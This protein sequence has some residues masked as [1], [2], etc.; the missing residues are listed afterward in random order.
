[1][2]DRKLNR[3][4][5]EAFVPRS[6]EMEEAQLTP[7]MARLGFHPVDVEQ[8]RSLCYKND[9][10]PGKVLFDR[11]PEGFR[12]RFLVPTITARQFPDD[13]PMDGRFPFIQGNF[14]DISNFLND[15]YDVLRSA[16]ADSAKRMATFNFRPILPALL[17]KIGFKTFID[18]VK[19]NL[20]DTEIKE[21]SNFSDFG[22]AGREGSYTFALKPYFKLRLT[23]DV[24]PSFINTVKLEVIW[25][26]EKL[27]ARQEDIPY[28]GGFDE[29]CAALGPFL[30]EIEEMWAK[31]GSNP[32]E[33]IIGSVNRK[34]HSKSKPR[35]S[36]G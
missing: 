13:M 7:N 10:L 30:A 11:Q 23:I 28:E 21:Y 26:R 24:E 5:F 15:N 27:R 8:R 31:M 12:L 6:I 2:I 22:E 33:K 1:M 14:D 19:A 3:A 34:K 16:I 25:F 4:L 29:L 17:A 35:R 36:F 18:E 20:P 9:G 32:L